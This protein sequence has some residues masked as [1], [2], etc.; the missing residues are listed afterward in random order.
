MRFQLVPLLL[1]LS[2]CVTHEQW[3][4]GVAP[5][6]FMVTFVDLN[7]H[8]VS[9]VL[10]K[11][12]GNS[13]ISEDL[14]ALD[15]VSNE[16]GVLLFTRKGYGVSGSSKA[17]WGYKWREASTD[18]DAMCKFYIDD[19]VVFKNRLSSLNRKTEIVVEH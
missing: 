7:K 9:G 14:N 6:T 15:A 12:E 1:L 10:M 8:P 16:H 5:I 18:I 11:C 3:E 19:I 2:G 17:I 13:I 4:G